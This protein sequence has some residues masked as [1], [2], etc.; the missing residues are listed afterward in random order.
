MRGVADIS[1]RRRHT[2]LVSDWSS[3]VCSSDL[4]HDNPGFPPEPE[5][6]VP[7]HAEEPCRLGSQG[8]R[9][10]SVRIILHSDLYR[11]P[12]RDGTER[13]GAFQIAEIGRAWGRERSRDEGGCGYFKQKTAYEVGQ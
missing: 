8:G 2:R 7:A 6:S 3:D 12:C 10:K 1:S 5:S 4:F 9:I 13:G 11:S